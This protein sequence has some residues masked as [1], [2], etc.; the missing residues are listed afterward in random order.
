[1]SDVLHTPAL[2]LSLSL[3]ARSLEPDT[4]SRVHLVAELRAIAAG[5]EQARPPLSIVFT[6]D[7]S[8]SMSG[9][10]I[11]HVI[12]SIDRIVAL[13]EPT[14]RVAV[15]A[16]SDGASEI[17]PLVHASAEQRKLISA[18]VHRLAANG[19]THMESGLRRAAALLPPRELHER[20]VILLLSDGAPN[21]GQHSP[22]ELATLAKSL[23][24]HI[25]LSTL[26]FGPHHHEDLLTK[27]SAAGAGRYHFIADPVMCAVEFAQAIGAQ[28]DVVAE[29]IDLVLTPAPGVEV[30][31]F[32]GSPEVRFSASSVKLTVGDLLDGGTHLTVADLSV[33]PQREPGLWEILS[34]RSSYRRA[35]ERD[36]L[37]IEK[38]LRIPVGYGE[39]G[40]AHEVR[41]QVLRARADE[42]RAEARKLADRNQFEGAAAVLRKLI[43]E[44]ETQP[45]FT[46][47]DGSPLAETL[48][49]LVDEAVAMERKPNAEQYTTF[50]RTQWSMSMAMPAPPASDPGPMSSHVM[51]GVA[52]PLPPAYL[53]N[54][55][56]DHAHERY[57]L[58]SPKMI[59]GRT[60][61]ADIQL[62]DSNVSRQHAA[63]QGQGGR[64]YVVDLGS[65]NTTRVNGKLLH[66]PWPLSPGDLVKIGNIELRYEE[67]PASRA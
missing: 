64:F 58:N 6:I 43:R 12:Q 30:V 18:R 32:L 56:D 57:P 29:A 11:E 44:I 36:C 67:N 2:E 4:P 27:I 37:Q 45:G 42:A 51:S 14:D 17:V 24:P 52:G 62:K 49:Q 21:R 26:G 3:D 48:E 39:K 7:A 55:T 16:F 25:A 54:V 53:L 50:R 20:Q 28:G 15:V 5:I 38:T 61:S 1:L 13:L 22:D 66:R 10:P 23:R 41:A 65:T 46:P 40:I 34:A 31:R 60:P 9:P 33:H 8:G 19:A 59:I 63:I 35:G 47:N